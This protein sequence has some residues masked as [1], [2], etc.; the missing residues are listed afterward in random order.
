VLVKPAFRNSVFILNGH[1]DAA[2]SAGYNLGLSHRRA[3]AVRRYLIER[4]GLAPDALMVAGY[5]EERLKFV[6]RPLA[7]ENRR[8]EVVNATR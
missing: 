5:G 4:F 3:Q 6:D 1:T 7:A 8:V 2:G